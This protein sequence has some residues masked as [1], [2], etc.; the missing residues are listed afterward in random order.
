[1]K[2]KEIELTEMPTAQP[3]PQ[4]GP[5][6]HQNYQLNGDDER[7]LKQN[8]RTQITK[9]YADSLDKLKVKGDIDN[10]EFFQAKGTYKLEDR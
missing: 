1:M 9:N 8:Y 10:I 5:L 2:K 6:P 7:K 4:P 3:I